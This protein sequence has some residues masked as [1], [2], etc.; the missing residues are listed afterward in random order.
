MSIFG[1]FGSR[2]QTRESIQKEL[3]ELDGHIAFQEKQTVDPGN[4]P[5]LKKWHK[6]KKKLERKLESTQA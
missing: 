5:L 6:K 1:L 3:D 2:N 4:D